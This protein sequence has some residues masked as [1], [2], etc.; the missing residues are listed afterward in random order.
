MGVVL[1]NDGLY[2]EGDRFRKA[3]ETNEKPGFAPGF[4]AKKSASPL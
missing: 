2:S 1:A 4:L 3:E